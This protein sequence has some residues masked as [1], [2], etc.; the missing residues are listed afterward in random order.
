M[1]C[2]VIFS[3]SL[4]PPLNYISFRTKSL[5]LYTLLY[6]STHFPLNFQ[7]APEGVYYAYNDSENGSGRLVF[8]SRDGSG[9]RPLLTELAPDGPEVSEKKHP[10]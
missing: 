5:L 9:E 1:S 3:H 10:L 4:F 6:R 2:T 8:Y 7:P